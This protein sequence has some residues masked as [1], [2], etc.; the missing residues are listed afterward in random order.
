MHKME[1]QIFS[2]SAEAKLPLANSLRRAYMV[3]EGK[4]HP[5]DMRTAGVS[6]EILPRYELI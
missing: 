6:L 3:R 4:S 5:Y 1:E 2:T